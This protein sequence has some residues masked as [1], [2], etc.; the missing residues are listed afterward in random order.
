MKILFLV[1]FLA[2][3]SCLPN[4]PE[5]VANK[6]EWVASM[7]ATYERQHADVPTFSPEQWIELVGLDQHHHVIFID[8]RSPQERAISRLPNAITVSELVDRVENERE[9]WVF[10]CTNGERS[11]PEAKLAL[12]QG[13]PHVAYLR[14][15]VL[16][17]A[18]QNLEFDGTHGPTR[19][20]HIYSK[21]WNF[22]PENY[23]AY[24]P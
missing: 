1:S 2:L 19:Q 16:A 23:D 12:E 14:G 15:G 21:A 6:A 22:L 20:V 8:V 4:K 9:L 18:H 7:A 13:A 24:L 10:Y 3:T 11:A 5:R 17:W